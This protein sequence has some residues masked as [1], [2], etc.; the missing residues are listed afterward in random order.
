M[1]RGHGA[2]A[3]AKRVCTGVLGLLGLLEQI[4]GHLFESASSISNKKH[5]REKT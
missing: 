4:R 1:G 2:E 5:V 3:R